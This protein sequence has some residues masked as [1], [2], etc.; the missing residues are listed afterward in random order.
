M[1]FVNKKYNIAIVNWWKDSKL[2]QILSVVATGCHY[3]LSC[4]Y[5]TGKSKINKIDCYFGT[6]EVW[7][8]YRTVL[9]AC[10]KSNVD[11]NHSG[12]CGET[13]TL[14]PSNAFVNVDRPRLRSRCQ[15]PSERVRHVPLM[16][17]RI[18]YLILQIMTAARILCNKNLFNVWKHFFLYSTR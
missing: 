8:N 13:W 14:I 17:V 11:S 6:S 1:P 5:T 15:G 3:F 16:Q 2:W 9:N 12:V 10:V 7:L 18:A 4:M